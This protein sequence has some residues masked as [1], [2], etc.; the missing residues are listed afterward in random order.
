MKRV[1]TQVVIV[2]VKKISVF[3]LIHFQ[4]ILWD[5]SV[6]SSLILQR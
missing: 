3:D 1:F 2:K 5:I 6:A 4:Q